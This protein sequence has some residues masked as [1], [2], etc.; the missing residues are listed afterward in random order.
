MQ[1]SRSLIYEFID[2]FRVH[3]DHI[4]IDDIILYK[5]TE[6]FVDQVCTE[7]K[8]SKRVSIQQDNIIAS[9]F[10]HFINRHKSNKDKRNNLH[11]DRYLMNKKEPILR[12]ASLHIL[13]HKCS[14]ASNGLGGQ[15]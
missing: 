8:F 6:T 4:N 7:S 14:T 9:D 13:F 11:K 5:N 15:I 3:F 12:P 1:S 2:N 10:V